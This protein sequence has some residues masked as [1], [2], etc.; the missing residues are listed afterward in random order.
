MPTSPRRGFL[1]GAI[2]TL[3][4]LA[5]LRA[6]AARASEPAAAGA[7]PGRNGPGWHDGDDGGA[8]E[9]ARLGA[10]LARRDAPLARRLAAEVES[11]LPVW[12]RLAGKGRRMRAARRLFLDPA[13]IARD[14][15]QARVQS[16][17]GWILAHGEAALVAYAHAL[18]PAP[19][20]DSRIRD[21]ADGRAHGA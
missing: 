10:W 3:A 9:I 16:V 4:A 11:A 8:S 2:R 7:L 15:A 14:L 6:G 18:S 19:A 1:V 17:D 13:R 20:P 21:A 5:W 12:L